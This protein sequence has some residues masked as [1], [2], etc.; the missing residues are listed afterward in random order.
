M[1]NIFYFFSGIF[2][3]FC[4]G[5]EIYYFHSSTNSS[6]GGYISCDRNKALKDNWK[7]IKDLQNVS[8]RSSK[9]Q[10]GKSNGPRARKNSRAAKS[11]L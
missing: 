8:T 6:I 4:I 11:T 7:L 2:V 3:G 10:A 5:K 9:V 1:I